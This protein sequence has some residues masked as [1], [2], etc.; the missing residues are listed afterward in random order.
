MV[1]WN[2]R[3]S[4]KIQNLDALVEALRLAAGHWQ[5][6]LGSGGACRIER[7]IRQVILEH[8]KQSEEKE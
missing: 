2:Q 8:A 1:E 6:D 3:M 5:G 4:V 7:E